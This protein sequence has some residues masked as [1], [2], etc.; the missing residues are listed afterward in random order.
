[1]IWIG[2]R[3]LGNLVGSTFKNVITD[4][5]K[6]ARQTLKVL[7]QA[8]YILFKFEEK[9][10]ILGIHLKMKAWNCFKIWVKLEVTSCNNGSIVMDGFN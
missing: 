10:L 6:I 1:M 5:L 8:H 2:Q 9:C 4:S 3:I 7:N